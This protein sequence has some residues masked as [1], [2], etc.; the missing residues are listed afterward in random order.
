MSGLE[1][2]GLVL[3]AF[4]LAIS[5]LEHWREAADVLR[6]MNNFEQDWGKTL[7]DIKDEYLDYQ[8]NLKIL[9]LPLVCDEKLDEDQLDLLLSDSSHRDWKNED[10]T[11]AL[12]ARSDIAHVRFMETMQSLQQLVWKLLILL[13][14]DKPRTQARLRAAEDLAPQDPRTKLRAIALTE[15]MKTNLEYRAEQLKF[16]FGQ[17]RRVELLKEIHNKND[18]LYRLMQKSE[19]VASFQETSTTAISP[20]AVKSLLRYSKDA[21]RVY[22]L[23]YRSWGCQCLEKH[24]AHLWLQHRTGPTFELKL[25]VLWSSQGPMLPSCPPWSSQGLRI[26]RIG[27]VTSLNGASSTSGNAPVMS[28]PRVHAGIIPATVPLQHAAKNAKLQEVPQMI[29][30]AM[31]ASGIPVSKKHKCMA[32]QAQAVNSKPLGEISELCVAMVA[33][34][35][36]AAC[37][38][39]LT[40]VEQGNKYSVESQPEQKFTTQGTTLREVLAGPSR[41]FVRRS[42]RYRIALAVASSQLQL[43]STPWVRKQW[44]AQDIRFP[45]GGPSAPCNIL[46]D[47]PYVS[48]E[49]NVQSGQAAAAPNGTDKSFACLGIMLMEL[50]FGAR[51]EDHE[52]W[53]SPGF[54]GK[55]SI[56]LFRQMVARQWADEVEGEVGA[57]MSAAVMW[58]LNE[59]P[60]TLDGEQWRHDLAHKVVLPLQQ[61]CDCFKGKPTARA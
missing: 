16:G 22:G 25:L 50:F 1:I 29:A 47:R 31:A 44:E 45:C 19:I 17:S 52:L 20:K 3:G 60:T 35:M 34:G 51:L 38:G 37:I 59:S 58:C 4:P 48:A 11:R 27:D 41:R 28:S 40:D 18:T 14:V 43:Q 12:S 54:G 13:G 49:F 42:D 21:D 30:A 24:C 32:K 10:L 33:C 9:L 5:A 6:L 7:D 46:F 23:I 61:G 15:M 8:L 39:A 55:E 56:T 57:D 53:S 26:T 2:I 36:S